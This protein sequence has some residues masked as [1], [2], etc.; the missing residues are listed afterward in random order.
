ME[1]EQVSHKARIPQVSALYLPGS[2]AEVSRAI[3]EWQKQCHLF[4]ATLNIRAP[5]EIPD[6][7]AFAN[8]DGTLELFVVI[9]TRKLSLIVAPGDWSWIL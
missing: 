4:S 9:G 1:S 8:K 6:E 2:A 7:Q 5:S 3:H